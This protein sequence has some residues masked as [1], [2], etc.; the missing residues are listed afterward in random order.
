MG[1]IFYGQTRKSRP[2]LN[3]GKKIHL[4][5]FFDLNRK[6]EEEKKKN[7]R[8][9]DSFFLN[10]KLKQLVF[11]YSSLTLKKKHECYKNENKIQT[12]TKII[13][14]RKGD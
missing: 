8:Y 5:I 7:H 11:I 10:L 12:G 4:H 9:S 13:S 14:K 6:S 3:V 2:Q 1:D